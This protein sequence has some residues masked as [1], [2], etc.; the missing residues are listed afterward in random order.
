M[1]EG[2]VLPGDTVRVVDYRCR[3]CEVIVH[4]V[5]RRCKCGS[6]RVERGW[7]AS[8]VLWEIGDFE[9]CVDVLVSGSD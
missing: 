1:P 4:R 8:K 6:V 2:R 9:D 5:L 3:R 7:Y